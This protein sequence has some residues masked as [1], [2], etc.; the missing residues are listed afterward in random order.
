MLLGE[1]PVISIVIVNFPGDESPVETIGA[2]GSDMSVVPE[3]PRGVCLEDVPEG[4]LWLYGALGDVGDAVHPGSVV[5]ELSVPVN[6]DGLCGVFVV[7]VDNDRLSVR[8]DEGGAGSDS[9]DGKEGSEGP[10]VHRLWWGA[11]GTWAGVS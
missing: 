5:L 11:L 6:G 2:G 7:E 3:G 4:V 8:H 1:I 10:P 9:V